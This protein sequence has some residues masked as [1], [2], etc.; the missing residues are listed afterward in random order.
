[1]FKTKD[2]P[3]SAA[4]KPNAEADKLIDVIAAH[5]SKFETDDTSHLIFVCATNDIEETF[6]SRTMANGTTD[7]LIDM[8]HQTL[9]GHLNS[10][11]EKQQQVVAQA[12][13]RTVAEHDKLRE[14]IKEVM[15]LMEIM[16]A[17][18]SLKKKA[19]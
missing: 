19:A 6:A 3:K 5:V 8:L 9:M 12:I 10:K 2:E 4:T 11:D 13:M 16:G 7:D 15:P 17:I 1:M 18:G 14:T